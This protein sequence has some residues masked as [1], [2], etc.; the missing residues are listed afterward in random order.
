M[1]FLSTNAN[2]SGPSW[3]SEYESESE[4]STTRDSSASRAVH[5]VVIARVFHVAVVVARCCAV[6]DEGLDPR[7]A[8]GSFVTTVK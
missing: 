6:G 2:T 1:A 7:G 4:F 5:V 8:T 3:L